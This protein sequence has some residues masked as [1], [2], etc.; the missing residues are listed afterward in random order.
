MGKSQQRHLPS[1]SPPGNAEPCSHTRHSFHALTFLSERRGW[2]RGHR[3]WAQSVHTWPRMLDQFP[4]SSFQDTCWSLPFPAPKDRQF[5]DGDSELRER[6]RL[7]QSREYIPNSNKWMPLI[8]HFVSRITFSYTCRSL[9][10][11][12]WRLSGDVIVILELSALD[13][14]GE[15]LSTK[16]LN[17][18]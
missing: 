1:L 17:T 7:S 12:Q 15:A 10:R 13:L 18:L 8:K 9:I 3:L 11:S 5:P 4:S 16:C 6:D 2:C 14:E